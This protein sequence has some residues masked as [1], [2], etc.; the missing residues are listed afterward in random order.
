VTDI[1]DQIPARHPGG[2]PSL[3]AA[4]LAE[5]IC[6]RLEAGMSLVEV[7][8]DPVMP[9]Y[10]TVLRWVAKHPEFR[11]RYARAREVQLHVMAEEI[12]AIADDGKNDWM[13]RNDPENPG[14]AANGEHIQRSRLRVDARK[15][16]LS[17]LARDTYG[18]RTVNEHTGTVTLEALVSKSYTPPT[19]E[20][21]SSDKD[22][23]Q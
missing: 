19:I 8:R 17:K 2:A 10:S 4:E 23:Q 5:E 21:E 11:D 16:L 6:V 12:V 7:C 9:H 20:H 13:E 14:F 1:M 3:Y 18:D 15:W 22:D